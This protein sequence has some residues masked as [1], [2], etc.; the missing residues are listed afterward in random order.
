V[1]TNCR[2]VGKEERGGFSVRINGTPIPSHPKSF[3]I[4]VALIQPASLMQIKLPSEILY[5]A[6]TLKRYLRVNIPD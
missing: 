5:R 4:R 3:L 1:T 2:N 6:A